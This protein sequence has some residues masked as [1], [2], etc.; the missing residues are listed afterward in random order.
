M[1]ADTQNDFRHARL[2]VGVVL[3]R[4]PGV[5]RWASEA[6]SAVAVLP[7]AGAGN[8][9]ELRREGDV[10][11]FHAATIDLDLHRAETEAYLTA[12][13]GIPPSVFVVMRRDP[14][15]PNARPELV[16]VTASAFEAQDYTDN[17]EDIVDRVPMPPGLE[18]WI[19]DFVKRHHREQAFIK[20]KRRPHMDARTEDGIGDPRVRQASDVYRS[21]R[22]IKAPHGTEPGSEDT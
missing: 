8:W 7:G 19:G 10:V 4:R 21:P 1:P 11:D 15:R 14:G 22:S 6:W 12:L 17:G 13:N 2:A 18:A 3:R 5:T 20:R 9:R 16:T